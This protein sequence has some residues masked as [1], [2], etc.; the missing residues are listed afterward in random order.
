[1]FVAFAWNGGWKSGY[2]PPLVAIAAI[3]G[4]RDWRLGL[5]VGLVGIVPAMSIGS[6]AIA[7]DQYSY[8]TRLDAWEIVLDMA[9]FNP[10]TGFGPANYS[11]YTRLFPFRGYA[12]RINSHNQYVDI[13]AQIGLL[14][15]IC[16]LWFAWEAG[17]M[18]W[19][20]RKRA[21]PGFARAYVYGAL[22]GGAATL[23]SGVLADWFLPYVY[24]IGLT[25]LRGSML[26]WLFMGGLVSIEQIA[27]RQSQAESG[28]AT[29]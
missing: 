16:F 26:A 4:F 18:G 13:I 5:L 10:V 2:L 21:S 14:G 17:W 22:G 15:L 29:R 1:M 24:N 11:W 27:H 28:N 6:E 19:K 25:G 9:K 3:I 23:A 20:L 7:T 8:S 12:A